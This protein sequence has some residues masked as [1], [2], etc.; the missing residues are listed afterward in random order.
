MAQPFSKVQY[1][2]LVAMHVHILLAVLL[3]AI[4]EVSMAL[5]LLRPDLARGLPQRKGAILST[6]FTVPKECGT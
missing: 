3:F 5:P 2:G 4:I 6:T 1:N